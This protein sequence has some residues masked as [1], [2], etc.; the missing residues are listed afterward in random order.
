[1]P[2]EST[3]AADPAAIEAVRR[4]NRFHTRL[5]GALDAAWMGS[6][7]P[8]AQV[9][10]LYELAHRDGPVAADLA[11]ALGIDPG[12]LS[13]LLDGMRRR[14]W[15]EQT[16]APGDARRRRLRLTDSGRAAFEPLE[17]AGRE[18]V[19]A[20]L[21]PLD[22]NQRHALL[23]AMGRIERLLGPLAGDG[24]AATPPPPEPIVL[25]GHRPGDLGWVVSRHGALYAREFGWDQR[26]EGMVADIVATFV[27]RYDPARERCWIAERSGEPVGSVFVVRESKKVAKLRMLLVE[28]SA[29]GTGLGRRLVREA[30]AFA[31]A[32]GYR[33]MVLWTNDVLLAARG[34]YRDEGFELV[35]SEPHRSFGHDLVGE[36]WQKTL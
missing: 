16:P 27:D 4:F 30:Q 10:L 8:L 29:R 21:A 28:P 32:A 13:R 18:Q 7:L 1:M 35:K 20:W 19:G 22:A 11:V 31:H 6:A 23:D 9:R 34:I 14:G 12:Y 25:R 36:Y 26:F 2:T 5:A 17:R 3:A 15:V 24:S 33:K